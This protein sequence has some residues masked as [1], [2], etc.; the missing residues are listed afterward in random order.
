MLKLS[1]LKLKFPRL[2]IPV[3]WALRFGLGLVLIYAG[4]HAL[5]DPISWLGFIPQWVG[6]FI[7]LETFLYIHA[8]FELVLG[9][10][11]IIGLWLPLAALVIFFNL[12]AILLFFGIDD[13]TFRDFGL[14]MMALALFLVSTETN[15]QT[16]LDQ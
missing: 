6:N 14:L 16:N 12:L 5:M 8:V 2:K 11:L 7:N 13:I 3:D 15:K 4:T 9:L 10:M 1:F